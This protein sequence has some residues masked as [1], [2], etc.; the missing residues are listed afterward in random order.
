MR[1]YISLSSVLLLLLENFFERG[2]VGID[3]YIPHR[4]Y[5][6]KAHLPP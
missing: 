3:V 4:N 2:Q 5:Q 6:V 1:I